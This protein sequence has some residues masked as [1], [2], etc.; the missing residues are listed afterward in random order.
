MIPEDEIGQGVGQL[1]EAGLSQTVAA[2]RHGSDSGESARDH[3]LYKNATIHVDGLF[4]CSWEGQPNCNHKPEKLTACMVTATSP[5]SACTR[6]ASVPFPEMGS[7][8][9]GTSV[10]T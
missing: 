9:S 10:T 8:A 7:P 2:R 6:A 5:T 1:D 4:H 3:A